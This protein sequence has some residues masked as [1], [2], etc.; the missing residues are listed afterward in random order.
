MRHGTTR[1]ASTLLASA[2]AVWVAA[3]GPRTRLIEFGWDEPDTAA[4]RRDIGLMERTPFDGCVFS[5]RCAQTRGSFTWGFWGRQAFTDADLAPAH[6]D[7]RATRLRRFRHNF[8]RVNVTPADLDWFDDFTPV[9]QNARLAGRL[10]RLGRARGILFDVEQYQSRLFNYRAQRHASTRS[11]GAY[12]AQARR[13][14][15]DVMRALQDGYPHLTVL[16]TFGHTLPWGLSGFGARPLAETP[17]GLLAPFVDGLLD[18][19][20]GRTRLV[21]GFESSYGYTQAAHFEG[22]RRLFAQGALPIV[23]AP[24]T[25][26]RHMRLAFGIWMDFEWRERGWRTDD[27]AQNHFSPARFEGAV[28]HALE[29]T[30]EYVWYVDALERAKRN[31]R[32]SPDSRR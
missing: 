10:A 1:A 20:R 12:A 18:G 29:Q 7:L 19:V 13:R 3:C 16:L 5:V 14:G 27:L 4:L 25:Y 32:A 15:K 21:D 24:E 17:Y 28:T 26:R 2:I 23:A 8:L 22:A 30:D 9:L 6:A 31:A 11:W